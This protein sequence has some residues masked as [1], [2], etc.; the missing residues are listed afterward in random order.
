MNYT[1]ISYRDD[2]GD[3]FVYRT[4]DDNRAMTWMRRWSSVHPE[5]L[6]MVTPVA[7]PDPP[8][9]PARENG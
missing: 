3:E 4:G 2:N 7:N 1:E 6:F 5:N 8:A 9:A